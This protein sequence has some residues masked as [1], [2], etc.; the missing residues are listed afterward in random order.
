MD[1]VGLHTH[2]PFAAHTLKQPWRPIDLKLILGKN[3]IHESKQRCLAHRWGL[4][5]LELLDQDIQRI[6]SS[7]T[8][9]VQLQVQQHTQLFLQRQAAQCLVDALAARKQ[10]DVAVVATQ[11]PSKPPVRRSTRG[12]ELLDRHLRVLAQ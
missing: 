8:G 7:R 3:R 5:A 6:C 10:I 2:P 1:P 9:L 4:G 12:L 11:R